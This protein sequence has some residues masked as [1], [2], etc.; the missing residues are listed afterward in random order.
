MAGTATNL[1]NY[2]EVLKTYYLDGIQEYLNH[3]TIL[4]D[5]IEVNEKDISGKSATIESH[6]GRSTGTGARGDGA[7]LP[8]ANYQK[9]KTCT[10]PM[11]YIYGRIEVTGPTIAATRDAKGAYGKALDL[12]VR[13]IV[14]DLGKECNR[15]DWGAGYGTLARWRSTLGATSYTL[16]KLYRANTAGGDGFGS[17]F[18]GKYLENRGDAV[19]VVLSSMS[20]ASAA[21]YTVDLTDIDVSALLKGTGF[22]TITVTDPVVTEAAGTFYVRPASL[23]AAAAS[24]TNRLEP[25]GLRGL[26]TDT[27]LDEISILDGTDAGLGIVNDP[28]QGLAVA[29][30]PWFK[31]IVDSHGS[32]RYAGDRALTLT[33]MQTMF[34]MVEEAAGKD[35]GPSLML[36]TRAIRREYLELVR[37]DK[38]FVN[39]LELDGGWTALDY[40][41]VPF[42]VDN[43]AIDGEIYFLTLGDIQCYRMSDYDWMQKDG[44]IL[45]RISGY[46]T[47]EAVLFRY[48]EMGI[49]NRKTQGV[50]TDI[51]YSKS[52]VEGYNS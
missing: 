40:N 31:S 13:G 36:T 51:Q 43:D 27:D 11:Q 3:S 38:R 4:K 15:M 14:N 5:L 28:L 9:F 18:G 7:A 49:K 41:G 26:V 17:A 20:S 22:D 8:S 48:H 52:D 6:Y 1:S 12:E 2:D 42:T 24:G 10:V 37:A 21:T 33:L 47:Y 19:P 50:L 32:G 46:D 16:Q 45:S 34:D 44:A 29:T 30:Y 39:T 23:G 25:M 35:Y